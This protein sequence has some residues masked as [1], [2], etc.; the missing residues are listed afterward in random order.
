MD[1]LEREKYTIEKMVQ[2]YCQAH[3]HTSK[4]EL[5]TECKSELDYAFKRIKACPFADKKPD[6]QSCPIHCYKKDHKEEMKKIMRFA[7]PRMA[8]KHPWLTLMHFYDKYVYRLKNKPQKRQF[9]KTL[10][11]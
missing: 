7:G 4:R 6:C 5:C 9:N 1:R 10:I 2:I 8:Y 11:R 3:H